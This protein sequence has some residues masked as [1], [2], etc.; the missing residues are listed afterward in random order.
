MNRQAPRFRAL[1][2]IGMVFIALGFGQMG[3]GVS[4]SAFVPVG[5]VFI[6]LGLRNRKIE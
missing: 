2:V 5:I 4:F 1:I 6:V 3:G